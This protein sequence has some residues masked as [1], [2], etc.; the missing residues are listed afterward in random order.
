MR[1]KSLLILHIFC[2]F[3]LK[4]QNGT[5]FQYMDS[6]IEKVIRFTEINQSN[7]NLMTYSIQLTAN[8]TPQSIK[9]MKNKYKSL[10]PNETTD[11]IFEPPYFKLITGDYLDKKEAEKKLK[12]IQPK[13]K[14]A[15][16][17]KREINIED[18][19]LK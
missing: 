18:L 4:S 12:L 10:F 11:K 6:L 1:A 19:L 2:T 5:S 14:S 9:N 3:I 15:F 7:K 17:L 8:E 13:F 16:I